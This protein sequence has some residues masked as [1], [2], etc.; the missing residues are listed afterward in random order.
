MRNTLL[1][2]II[3]TATLVFFPVY[4]SAA[5]SLDVSNPGSDLNLSN[6][7]KTTAPSPAIP[8]QN[9]LK[10]EF[11]SLPAFFK[12]LL[13][14]VIQIAVPIATLFMIYA[15]FLLVTA[16]GDETKVTAAKK[17]FLWTAV[18]TVVLLGSW[19][20]FQILL[21]TIEGVTGYRF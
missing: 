15:G 21:N 7:P 16:G 1:Y 10:K 4:A 2:L 9:P 3:V 19:L 14:I 13:D 18:G 20:L 17:T 11:S 6:I 12:A 8:L 5:G